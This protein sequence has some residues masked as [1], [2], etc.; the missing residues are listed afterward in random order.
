VTNF[1]TPSRNLPGRPAAN[2]EGLQSWQPVFY[3]DSNPATL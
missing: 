2:C 1:K 3:R